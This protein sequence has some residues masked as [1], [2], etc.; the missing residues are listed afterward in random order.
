MGSQDPWHIVK[1]N[2]EQNGGIT[3]YVAFCSAHSRNMA[4]ELLEECLA[5]CLDRLFVDNRSLTVEPLHTLSQLCTAFIY[6][7]EAELSSYPTRS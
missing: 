2:R 6:I 5:L 3:V 7:G 4:E 1:R